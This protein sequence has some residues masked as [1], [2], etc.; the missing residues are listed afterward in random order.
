[1]TDAFLATMVEQ[2][3][4]RHEAMQARREKMKEKMGEKEL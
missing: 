1:M 2:R 3:V 4:K